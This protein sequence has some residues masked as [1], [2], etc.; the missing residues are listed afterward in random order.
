M[1]TVRPTIIDRSRSKTFATPNFCIATSLYFGKVDRQLPPSFLSKFPVCSVV[2]N[3]T[4]E[5]RFLAA[6][7]WFVSSWHI[8]PKVASFLFVLTSEVCK[9]STEP[10][11]RWILSMQMGL[12]DGTTSYISEQLSHHPP[13]TAAL[14]YNP[15]HGIAICSNIAPAYIKF[16]GNSAQ[17]NLHGLSK[18]FVFGRGTVLIITSTDQHRRK[19]RRSVR[20]HSSWCFGQRNIDW[21]SSAR[22][23]RKINHDMP[24]NGISCWNGV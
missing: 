5:A 10:S 7:R 22:D 16:Y 13:H 11:C 4:P 2:D 18:I 12:D 17:T 24:I 1:I 3:Q 15:Q 21:Y 14:Y 23:C 9:E 6:V 19:I 8:R 20:V